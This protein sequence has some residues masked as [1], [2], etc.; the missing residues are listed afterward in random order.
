MSDM[1]PNPPSAGDPP[2]PQAPQQYAPQQYSAPPRNRSGLWI[3]LAAVIALLVGLGVGVAVAQPSKNDVASQ[4]N[5]ARAQVA[6]LQKQLTTSQGNATTSS[7]ARDKC[8][9]AATDA[10]DL[11]AQHEN[12]W[13]DFDTFMGTPSNSAAE[14][15]MIQHMNTQQQTMTAQRDVVNEELAACRSALG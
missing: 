5:E 7:G 2:P 9:K 14:A 4:R 3:G 8:S 15:E 10:K 6:D 12:L 11:I 13:S 1:S